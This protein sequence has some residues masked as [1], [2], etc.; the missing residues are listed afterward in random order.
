M[1]SAIHLRRT[2]GAS[3]VAV[4]IALVVAVLAAPP[5]AAKSVSRNY[6]VLLARADVRTDYLFVARGCARLSCLALERLD[7]ATGITAR[8]ARPPLQSVHSSPTGD[9]G[10]VA[11]ASKDVGIAIVGKI[12]APQRVY[13][14]TDGARKW[15]SVG[16]GSGYDALEVAAGGG[17]VVAL[18]ALCTDLRGISTCHDYRLGRESNSA[19]SWHSVAVPESM[20]VDLGAA[21]GGRI[22]GPVATYGSRVWLSEQSH[23]DALVRYSSDEGAHWTTYSQTWP[24]LASLSGC[25]LTP[26]ATSVLWAACPTGMQESFYR[27][28]DA[29][30]TWR[31]VKQAQYFGTGG[32]FFDPVTPSS[33][34]LDYGVP[35]HVLHRVGPSS[36]RPLALRPVKVGPIPCASIT[37]EAF[38]DSRYGAVICTTNDTA[39]APPQ[40]LETRDSGRAWRAAYLP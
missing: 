36:T 23:T 30:R 13:V 7:L 39:V 35:R 24:T 17:A 14:T 18:Y 31:A 16:L 3:V 9:L 2:I 1:R 27:S 10:V 8:V 6:P 26:V 15:R 28:T 38:S 32:G 25:S 12:G 21:Y 22:L 29:G 19:P 40:L 34:Y 37:S 11:F 20:S 5:G 4:V 33:A